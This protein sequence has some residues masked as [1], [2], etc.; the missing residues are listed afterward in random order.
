MNVINNFNFFVPTRIVYGRGVAEN[1]VDEINE[2]EVKKPLIVTDKGLIEVGLIEPF[3]NK[4]EDSG[5]QVSVFHNIMANPRD[6]NCEEGAQFAK[7]VGADAIVAIGGGSP[8]DTAKAISMLVTNPGRV[9]DYF[10]WNVPK[11]QGLP[12]I[13]IP[14]TAGTG[15]EVTIWA[16]ITNTQGAV[17]VK[18]AIGSALI[19]PTVAL[20]DPL[21]TLGLPPLLTAS[22]GMDALTHAI[23][24]YTSLP[25][26]P[27]SDMYALYAINYISKY[28]VPA[29]ANGDNVEARDYL[30]LGSLLAG[31]AFSNADTAAVHSMAEAIGGLYDIPHGIANSIFLPHVMEHNTLAKPEKFADIAKAMGQ[32]IAGLDVFEAAN[33]SVIAV[34]KLSKL[35]NIPDLKSVGVKE[36]DFETICDIAMKN[37]GTPDNP[38]KMTKE[39]FMEVLTNAYAG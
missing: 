28:L 6:V 20:V 9:H 16:V 13:T 19:C 5:F 10:G 39:G 27:I 17:H 26:N 8:M 2:L 34:K 37:L 4:L 3:K 38:R 24:A 33:K 15:S 11:K 32:D 35:V 12:L 1:L 30:M 29:Y 7:E 22:T 18:D 21:V 14:T 36:K 23:E 31:I 25:A